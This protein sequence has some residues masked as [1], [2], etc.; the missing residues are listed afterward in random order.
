MDK[1]CKLCITF[2]DK[3]V[4]STGQINN[5]AETQNIKRIR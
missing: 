3:P 2:S 5:R 1:W 4:S